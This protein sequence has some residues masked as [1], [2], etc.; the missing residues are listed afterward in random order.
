MCRY[1]T[2]VRYSFECSVSFRVSLLLHII[3][4][5]SIEF[6]LP[7]FIFVTLFLRTL[8]LIVF[9]TSYIYFTDFWLFLSYIN[10]DTFFTILNTLRNYRTLN[11]W[12]F[13]IWKLTRFFIFYTFSL[14]VSSLTFPLIDFKFL[15]YL[16]SVCGSNKVSIPDGRE[17]FNL[18]RLQLI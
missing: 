13:F 15:F 11:F 9:D 18:W 14:I 7:T 1:F 16:C 4:Y 5:G 10:I 17:I 12:M 6:L 2:F 8:K 3:I